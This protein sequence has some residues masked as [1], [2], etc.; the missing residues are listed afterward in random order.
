[1]VNRSNFCIVTLGP[2]LLESTSPYLPAG[3]LSPPPWISPPLWMNSRS[4]SEIEHPLPTPQI[5]HGNPFHWSRSM[6]ASPPIEPF[7][8]PLRV[9]TPIDQPPTNP[10]PQF[11]SPV[12]P[13]PPPPVI[14]QG[15]RCN[16]CSA[17]IE[18]V[19]H[20]CLDCPGMSIIS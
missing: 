8:P 9:L 7:I 1:M 10:L 11:L 3:P 2:H 19:R 15:V 17:T 18:G 5:L 13:P 16:V 4:P 12:N 14:H 6:T 20:K